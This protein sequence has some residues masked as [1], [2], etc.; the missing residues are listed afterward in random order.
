[1]LNLNH[2]DEQD[3]NDEN[4]CEYSLHESV[5]YSRPRLRS[6]M[7]SVV[8]Q[9]VPDSAMRFDVPVFSRANEDNPNE[10]NGASLNGE[11]IG[12]SRNHAKY[13]CCVAIERGRSQRDRISLSI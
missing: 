9:D 12:R 3:M 8:M 13:V 11:S 2:H 10:R 6:S 4:L 1:M 7:G 5:D